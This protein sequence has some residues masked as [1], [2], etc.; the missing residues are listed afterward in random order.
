MIGFSLFVMAAAI[1]YGI[2]Q[3]VVTANVYNSY[4]LP[5]FHRQIVASQSPFV[6]GLLWGFIATWWAGLGLGVV[7]GLANTLGTEKPLPWCPLRRQILL[8]LLIIFLLAMLTLVAV[9]L[10]LRHMTAPPARLVAVATTHNWSYSACAV[11]ALWLAW[12]V[13][14]RRKKAG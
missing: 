13:R 8:A 3:D 7:V 2:C 4:F 1:A 14:R 10:G 5:P 9:C 12:D 11:Y 6:L